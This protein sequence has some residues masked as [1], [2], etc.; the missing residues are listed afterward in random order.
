MEGLLHKMIEMFDTESLD[1]KTVGLSKEQV[2]EVIDYLQ[3]KYRLFDIIT[4][5]TEL[6]IFLFNNSHIQ[7]NSICEVFSDA[8]EPETY[9][10]RYILTFASR[11]E[12]YDPYQVLLHEIGHALQVAL[13]HQVMIVPESF[14]K[15]NKELV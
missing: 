6:E 2:D 4:Y 5:K 14:I 15:M 7:F 3:S 8:R 12:E 13:T 9:C 10:K 1:P 11:S